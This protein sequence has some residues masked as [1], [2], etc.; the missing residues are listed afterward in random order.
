[1]QCPYLA[2]FW[3]DTR[4]SVSVVATLKMRIRLVLRS[5]N[6]DESPIPRATLACGSAILI[7]PIQYWRYDHNSTYHSWVIRRCMCGHFGISRRSKSRPYR[8]VNHPWRHVRHALPLGIQ[9]CTHVRGALA[10]F[11]SPVALEGVLPAH[12]GRYFSL[13]FARRSLFSPVCIFHRFP[14]PPWCHT[15]SRTSPMPVRRSM[16]RRNVAM[17]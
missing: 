6:L 7:S 2:G 5:I 4:C 17:E 9:T 13:F 3:L 8:V 1:M 15:N 10:V 14:C 11:A 12:C 16:G